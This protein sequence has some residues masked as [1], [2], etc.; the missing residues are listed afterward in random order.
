MI[1]ERAEQIDKMLLDSLRDGPKY[2]DMG[3]SPVEAI[4]RC[5]A[6]ID[7]GKVYMQSGWV[8][9]KPQAPELESK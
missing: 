3:H 1:P 7:A 5:F 2:L 9:L 8:Y 4:E 6:L